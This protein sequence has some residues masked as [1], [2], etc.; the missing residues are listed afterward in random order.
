M[1]FNQK[2]RKRNIQ[3]ED[4]GKRQKYILILLY[5]KHVS[6]NPHVLLFFFLMFFEEAT[7]EKDNLGLYYSLKGTGV[8]NLSD[9]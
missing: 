1:S 8:V 3:I 6:Y 7:I 5:T 4:R 2:T 9:L